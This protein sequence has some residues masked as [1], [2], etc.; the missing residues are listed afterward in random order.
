M[1]PTELVTLNMRELDRFNVIQGVADGLVKPWRAAERLGLTTR[2]IWHLVVR[3]REHG[4]AGLV[5]AHRESCST[6]Y[7]DTTYGVGGNC[8][9]R[10][11]DHQHLDSTPPCK[12][13]PKE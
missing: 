3:L 13:L 7:R 5:S 9:S 4:P 8:A 6:D 2:Q 10:I 11:N 12:C 1:Q